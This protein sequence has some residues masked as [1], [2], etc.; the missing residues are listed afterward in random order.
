MPLPYSSKTP[1][2]LFEYIADFSHENRLNIPVGE[3]WSLNDVA[4]H[5]LDTEIQ[6]YS[7]LIAIWAEDSPILYNFDEKSW[8]HLKRE[9]DINEAKSVVTFI[10][11]QIKKMFENINEDLLKNKYGT[12]SLRGKQSLWDLLTLY[13]NHILSHQ[14]QA[15]RIAQLLSE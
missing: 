12:H 10:R 14:N 2:L 5:I 6:S 15:Q 4:I 9:V 13:E 3:K 8:A 11:K 1:E 7:R